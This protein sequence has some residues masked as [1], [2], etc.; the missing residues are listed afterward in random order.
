MHSNRIQCLPVKLTKLEQEGNAFVLFV[1]GH[2]NKTIHTKRHNALQ[3][4]MEDSLAFVTTLGSFRIQSTLNN[5][6]QSG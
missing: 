5:A 6:K 1:S 4:K 2:V 3:N